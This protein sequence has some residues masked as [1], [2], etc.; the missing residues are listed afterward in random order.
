M[1]NSFIFFL[2]W[3]SVC[4]NDAGLHHFLSKTMLVYS[5]F[6]WRRHHYRWRVAKCW[7]TINWLLSSECS[8]ACHTYCDMGHPFIMISDT[9]TYC[10]AFGFGSVSVTTRFNDLSLLQLGFEHPTFRL[11]GEPSYWLF[12]QR[13]D[14]NDIYDISYAYPFSHLSK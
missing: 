9:Y 3:T 2:C 12:H 7:P 5:L 4:C 13:D 6:T 14:L 8:F 11:Q 10:R 1:G